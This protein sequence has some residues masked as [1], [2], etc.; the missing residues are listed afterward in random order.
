MTFDKEKK[1]RESMGISL[2]LKGTKEELLR[3]LRAHLGEQE[4][5]TIRYRKERAEGLDVTDPEETIREAW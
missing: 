3:D 2:R 1:G 5:R 4:F